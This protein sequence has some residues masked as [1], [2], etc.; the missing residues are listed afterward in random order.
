MTTI[1]TVHE[2]REVTGHREAG[3]AGVLLVNLGTPKST[4]TGDVR[5]YLKEF[6]SDPRVIEVPRPIWWLILNGIILPF[7]SSR[8]AAAYRKIWTEQGSPLLVNSRQLAGRLQAELSRKT[9]RVRVM[10][11]MRYGEPSLKKALARLA[12]DNIQRL[13][14]LPM[15]PQYSATTTATIFDRIATLMRDM[16]WLPEYRFIAQYHREDGWVEAIARSIRDHQSAH[17]RPDKLVFSFHGIPKK[18]LLAGDP[19]HCQCLVSARLIADRL[20]LEQRD[21][22]VSFQSRLG[23]AE[24]L[25]PYTDERLEQLAKSGVKKVQVVCPGFSVDCLETLEEIAMEGKEEFLEAGGESLQ[26]IPALNAEPGHVEAMAELIHRH[27]QGWPEFSG[28]VADGTTEIEQR[29]ERVADRA[30]EL[31]LEE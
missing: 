3:R 25:K 22:E 27:G 28:A 26:Y 31:K 4:E 16:R 19:Y 1:K 13:L 10:I 23:R 9:P 5:R 6:L 24:W 20:G 2:A 30:R 17:G 12:D 11:A 21:W 14:V 29:L 18:Y 7:R 15:Y 8:S